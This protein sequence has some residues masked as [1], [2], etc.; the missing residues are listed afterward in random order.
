MKDLFYAI[1]KFSDGSKNKMLLKIDRYHNM[2]KRPLVTEDITS[3]TI[4]DDT[5]STTVGIKLMTLQL[6]TECP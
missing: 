1:Y 6:S 5:L 3:T 4:W 2:I